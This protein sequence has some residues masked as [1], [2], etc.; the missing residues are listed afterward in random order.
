[1]HETANVNAAGLTVTQS[2]ALL[3][4]RANLVFD[5]LPGDS[6]ELDCGSPQARSDSTLGGLSYCT[7]GGTGMKVAPGTQTGGSA[8]PACCDADG[9]GFGTLTRPT[10]LMPGATSDRIGSGDV[11]IQ[12]V[13]RDGV[14]TH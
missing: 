4:R 9:D 1:M 7:L 6:S 3:V 2:D 8:F 14:E 10:L 11:M 12:R 5:V 13:R